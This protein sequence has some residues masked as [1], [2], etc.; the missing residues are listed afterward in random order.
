MT[1]TI[2]AA[3]ALLFATRGNHRST[4]DRFCE[5]FKQSDADAVGSLIHR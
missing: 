4:T 2:P 3:L 1:R 5:Y